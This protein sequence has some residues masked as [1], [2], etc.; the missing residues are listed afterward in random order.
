MKHGTGLYKGLLFVYLQRSVN[1]NSWNLAILTLQFDDVTVKTIYNK[2]ERSNLINEHAP[3]REP[4]PLTVLR[5]WVYDTTDN[6]LKTFL[7][8]RWNVFLFRLLLTR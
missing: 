6:R 5:T 2:L 8:T 3:H 7:E 4:V 1:K